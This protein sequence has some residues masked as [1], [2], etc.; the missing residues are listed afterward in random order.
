MTI[1]ALCVWTHVADLCQTMASGSSNSMIDI[2]A[3]TQSCAVY[4]SSSGM[5]Q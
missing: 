5:E 3:D 1:I 4:K 2:L